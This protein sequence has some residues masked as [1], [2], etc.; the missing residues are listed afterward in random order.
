VNALVWPSFAGSAWAQPA[1]VVTE[2]T[3]E[4]TDLASVQLVGD[5]IIQL[6][7]WRARELRALFW[8]LLACSAWA[9]PAT[10]LAGT[11]DEG[12]NVAFFRFVVVGPTSHCGLR[13]RHLR[14][15]FWLLFSCSAWAQSSTV[16]AS[17]TGEGAGLASV[18]LIGVVPASHCGGGYVN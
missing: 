12:A 4:A 18:P 8:L 5:G 14:A 10:V 16:M 7:W 15:Q 1:S 13:A 6:L 9:Q 17:T 11:R 2:T 3:G